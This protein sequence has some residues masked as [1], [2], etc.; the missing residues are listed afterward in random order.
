MES[1]ATTGAG[2]SASRA[3]GTPE[4]SPARRHASNK[5]RC[6]PYLA[7][8]TARALLSGHLSLDEMMSLQR[9][10]TAEARLFHLEDAAIRFRLPALNPALA[11]RTG[12]PALSCLSAAWTAWSRANYYIPTL[13][14]GTGLM[15]GTYRILDDD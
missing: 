4:T 5:Q 7:L 9:V 10:G 1:T 8:T 3:C 14:V 6:S 12:Q 2:T 15:Y 13:V 11:M